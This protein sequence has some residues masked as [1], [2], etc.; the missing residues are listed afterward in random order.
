[1]CI[2]YICILILLAATFDAA[3]QQNDDN[4]FA[5]KGAVFVYSSL[6]P[7]TL[8]TNLL[9]QRRE[10]GGSEMWTTVRTYTAISNAADVMDRYE[11]ARQ[12]FPEY[13]MR[14]DAG[15][16]WRRWQLYQTFDSL[17][18]EVSYIPGQMAFGIVL[19]D[20][21]V[22]AGK[23]Y[24]YRVQ[25]QG[26]AEAEANRRTGNWVSYP[27]VIQAPAPRLLQRQTERDAILLQ[28]YSTGIIPSDKFLVYRASGNDTAFERID[29][30]AG[31]QQRGDTTVYIVHDTKVLFSEMYRYYI[32]PVNLFGGGGNI[33]SDTVPATCMNPQQLL[34]PQYVRA[35]E[36][37]AK[38]AIEV[39]F[40]LPDQDYIGSV[41]IM[42]SLSFD[43]GYEEVGIATPEDT[44]FADFRI[45]P[46]R[47]YYYYLQMTDKM[48]RNS[49][50]SV[51]TFG[52][53][54]DTLNDA[55]ARFVQAVRT[56]AGIQVTWENPPDTGVVSG[57][58]VY[59]KTGDAENFERIST[60]LP[61]AD[62]INTF[63]DSSR[64]L[65]PSL[66]YVYS[67]ASENLSNKVS[68][69]SVPAY[70][71][72]IQAGNTVILPTP[73]DVKVLLSNK[74][75]RLLWY[76]MKLLNTNLSFY[77]IY[78]KGDGVQDFRP[79]AT[80]Y[81]AAFTAFTDT[82]V[83]EG[84]GYIYAMECADDDGHTSAQAITEVLNMPASQLLPPDV[85]ATV[86]DAAVLL[87]WEQV[88]DTRV[89]QLGVYRYAKGGEPEKIATVRVNDLRFKDAGVK[90]GNTYYYYLQSDNV[91][92]SQLATSNTAYVVYE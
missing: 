43:E 31:A 64:T 81:P 5:G 26:E 11:E 47:K 86:E 8:K 33:V 1:M 56:P 32:T 34:T 87:T 37:I 15:E 16:A 4:S 3:A 20:T 58:Y 46:G 90:K 80:R 10:H 73:R 49:A 88:T 71:T 89:S 28:W 7:D 45:V 42:R 84:T 85:A 66:L 83:E 21:S 9:L 6:L 2:R 44:L 92:A 27:A 57:Y 40:L 65:Q 68:Q 17:L 18:N 79:V 75:A 30:F 62:S 77:N 36:N 78:R 70:V 51:K 63:I 23:T 53:L 67:V 61:V 14:F 52:L 29:V 50:R 69:H 48:G 24:Q 22:V 82:T 35:D 60:L 91:K 38:K 19:A 25:K 54:Q 41:H 55:P 72:G 74:S 13:D 12:L 76:D 59:R 39:R